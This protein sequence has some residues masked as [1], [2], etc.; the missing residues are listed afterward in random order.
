MNAIE[1]FNLTH[2]RHPESIASAMGADLPV[3]IDQAMTFGTETVRLI[4]RDLG[5]VI[6]RI[7]LSIS[8]V[9]TI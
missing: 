3:T 8:S 5:V 1:L 4:S 7:G 9:M 6:G 2:G